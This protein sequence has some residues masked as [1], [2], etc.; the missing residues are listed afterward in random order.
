MGTTRTIHN[1]KTQHKTHAKQQQTY[2]TQI[3]KTHK[4]KNKQ[5]NKQHNLT[6]IHKHHQNETTTIISK[7]IIY[8][9]IETYN[10]NQ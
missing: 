9:F 2:I 8:T 4:D 5:Q 3:A 7:H 10:H 6:Q 1:A